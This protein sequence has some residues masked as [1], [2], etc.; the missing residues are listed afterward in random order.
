MPSS[1]ASDEQAKRHH[2]GSEG[3]VEPVVGVVD[4]DEIGV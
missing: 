1:P 3:E 4:R 2:A